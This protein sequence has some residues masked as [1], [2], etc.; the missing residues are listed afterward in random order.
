MAIVYYVK[1]GARPDTTPS[2]GR[3]INLDKLEEILQQQGIN[4]QYCG[5]EPP[6]FNKEKPTLYPERVVVEIDANDSPGSIFT[7]TGFYF[8]P[9]LTPADAEPIFKSAIGKFRRP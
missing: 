4:Y 8:F 3:F 5:T 1:D 6:E 7:K 9:A 2:D